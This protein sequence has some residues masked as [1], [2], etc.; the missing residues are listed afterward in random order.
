MWREYVKEM[1]DYMARTNRALNQGASEE[2]IGRLKA[3]LKSQYNIDLPEEYA[4][5]L[6]E[7]DGL[8]FNVSLYGVDQEFLDGDRPEEV[9]GLLDM[10]DVWRE[11][12]WDHTYLFLGND[13]I[14]WYVYEPETG[15][16]LVLDL[17][18]GS[19]ME[20]FDHLGDLLDQELEYKRPL[21]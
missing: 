9:D 16:Y 17:P 18:S 10:N 21:S 2:S 1:R 12:E 7:I 3:A 20:E 13:D 6:R 19:R 14:S 8:G 5:V 15:K 11:N 4:D